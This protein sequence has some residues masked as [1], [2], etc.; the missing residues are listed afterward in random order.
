MERKAPRPRS[1]FL[2]CLGFQTHVRKMCSAPKLRLLATVL[3]PSS[4]TWGSVR[5]R[6]LVVSVVSLPGL[7]DDVGVNC[8]CI[9]H[10]HPHVG[11]REL[12]RIGEARHSLIPMGPSQ[13][14]GIPFAMHFW[15]SI[16][17]IRYRAIEHPS[18]ASV[19]PGGMTTI[20]YE[21][22]VKD[23]AL[24]NGFLPGSLLR[25]FRHRRHDIGWHRERRAGAELKG[26]QPRRSPFRLRS[27]HRPSWSKQS[28][29]RTPS[30][31]DKDVLLGFDGEGYG[32]RLNG[33]TCLN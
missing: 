6:L 28:R 25:R 26:Q 10:C 20:A 17:Q 27:R 22:L 4:L 30:N 16:A 23:L 9:L 1:E 29:A 11:E 24:A 15:W 12:R 32:N 3:N 33:G 19:H 7:V 18:T 14:D 21:C 13:D 8:I 31:R 5:V 2:F